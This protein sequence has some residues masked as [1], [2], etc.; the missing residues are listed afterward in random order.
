[1][2]GTD[3]FS[4]N[5]CQTSKLDDATIILNEGE[6]IKPEEENKNLFPADWPSV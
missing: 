3:I 1:M 2:I 4:P 6:Q 5:F